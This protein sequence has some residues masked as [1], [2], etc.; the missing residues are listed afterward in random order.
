[1]TKKEQTIKKGL[2]NVSL[3]DKI[4]MYGLG[5]ETE[6]SYKSSN[7]A[8]N[9]SIKED[10][11]NNLMLDD[12]GSATVSGTKYIIKYVTVKKED[13]DN[14]K[15]IECLRKIWVYKHGSMTNPFLKVVYV[16]DMDAIENAIYNGEFTKEDLTEINKC[17]V[18]KQTPKLTISKKKGEKNEN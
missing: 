2:T 14:D 4:D 10:L 18:I 1:M 11:M 12:N 15:L 17:K 3:E 9:E 8:L 13:F 16:P 5:K 7:N 6:L